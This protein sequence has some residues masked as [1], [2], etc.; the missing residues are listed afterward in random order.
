[1]KK[2]LFIFVLL[3]TLTFPLKR[4]LAFELNDL[5]LETIVK[6]NVLEDDE[7]Q[8]DESFGDYW[9]DEDNENGDQVIQFGTGFFVDYSGC[10][11]TNSHV[12]MDWDNT[13]FKNFSIQMADDYAKAPKDVYKAN[14]LF[15]DQGVD[16]A[17]LCV[18]DPKKE[19]H[20]FYEFAD[21]AKIN[22]LKIGEE[23]YNIGF[24]EIGG[25][26]FTYTTGA[27]AGFWDEADLNKFLG[28][29]FFDI[30][31]MKIIKSDSVTG[32][33][34]S[35]SPVFNEDKEVI[36]VIFAAAFMPSGINFIIS[37]DIIND[38]YE[39][40]LNTLATSTTCT[41]D[42][43]QNLFKKAGAYYYDPSC[44]IQRNLNTENVVQL[45]YQER[46]KLTLEDSLVKK[47]AYYIA[48]GSSIQNW[49][50]YLLKI[51][52]KTLETENNISNNSTF[53]N[54]ELESQ[55]YAYNKPRLED[56][57]LENQ[58]IIDLEKQ[59]EEIFSSLKIS[60]E[61]WATLVKAYIYGDYPIEAIAQAIRLGGYTVHPS[62][63][64][65]SWKNSKDYIEH[66]E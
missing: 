18:D 21:D 36:G 6:I 64:F 61:N 27:I 29:D 56:L 11:L 51:C 39:L 45:N 43:K 19:F 58:K 20:N 5:D 65:E 47:A 38:W 42:V 17:I 2:T 3:L 52:P 48:S 34:G 13:V 32:P 54:N 63:P 28:A 30:D 12:V 60:D 55:F 31:R 1:M 22:K 26:T 50:N 4:V 40:Y 46:C 62:I 23:L 35:G 24:P 25:E 53:L 66:M 37:G 33:G 9:E 8:Y 7:H 57:K 16:I 44:K 41:R 10:I 59:L 15:Y 14:L 49:W